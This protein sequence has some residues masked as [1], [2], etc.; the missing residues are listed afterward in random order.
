VVVSISGVESFLKI[1]PV[2]AVDVT[3]VANSAP[4]VSRIIREGHVIKS[5]IVCIVIADNDSFEPAVVGIVFAV[6]ET[7]VDQDARFEDFLDSSDQFI[8]THLVRNSEMLF[9]GQKL[10]DLIRDGIVVHPPYLRK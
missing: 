2:H 9:A 3:P 5:V 7:S 10:T 4:S 1:L 8:T 6:Q